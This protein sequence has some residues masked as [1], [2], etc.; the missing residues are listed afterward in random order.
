MT[1]KFLDDSI[2]SYKARMEHYKKMAREAIDENMFDTA[3]EC[4]TQAA[5]CKGAIEE[6]E[7]TIECMEVENGQ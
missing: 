2:R 1:I 7:F 3:A 6:L 5:K 4:I